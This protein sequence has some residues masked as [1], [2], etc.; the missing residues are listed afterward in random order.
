VRLK[1]QWEEEYRHRRARP[2]QEDH[3]YVRE[4][5]A[6]PKAGP[7]HENMAVLV[8]VGLNRK[9]EK[10]LLAI[11]EGFRE[12]FQ[13]WRDALWDIRKRGVRWIGTVI[14]DRLKALRKAMREVFPT[15]RMQRCFLPKMR[16]VLDK[17]PSRVHDD[18]L[19]ALREI[20][21]A[22]SRKQA[23]ALKKAFI[24]CYHRQCPEAVGVLQ[25]ADDQMFTY[26][27]FPRRHRI[28]LK[29]TNV[30]ESMFNAVK[31]RTDAAR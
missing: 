18:V 9:R 3:L 5:G 11:E 22:K 6:D 29:S 30:T 25:E 10:E 4:D 12:S 7:R 24:A 13:S 2:L 23:V 27:D 19:Q 16:N 14:D 26:F 8:V 20:Y 1:L 28:S 31:L 17:V 21:D 15:S